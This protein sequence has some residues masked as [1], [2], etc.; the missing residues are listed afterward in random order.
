VI[1]RPGRRGLAMIVIAID[2]LV[3]YQL[4]AHWQ[5]TY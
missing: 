2:V 5:A 1:R 3:I 4:T